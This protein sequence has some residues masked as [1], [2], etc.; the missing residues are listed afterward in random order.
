MEGVLELGELAR[1]KSEGAAKETHLK[2]VSTLREEAIA[3]VAEARQALEE[4]RERSHTQLAE[5]IEK[6]HDAR[7]AQLAEAIDKEQEERVA[8]DAALRDEVLAQAKVR[9]ASRNTPLMHVHSRR[10]RANGRGGEF[11]LRVC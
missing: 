2:A 6:E 11:V 1:Q 3:V 9:R 8:N 4:A 7:V 5:A 10:R